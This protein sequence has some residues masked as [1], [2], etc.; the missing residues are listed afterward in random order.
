MNHWWWSL[1]GVAIGIPLGEALDLLDYGG[2]AWRKRLA[3]WY[4]SRPTPKACPR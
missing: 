2:G 4:A 3:A 1:A